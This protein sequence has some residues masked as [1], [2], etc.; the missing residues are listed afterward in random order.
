MAYEGTPALSVPGPEGTL[1][2]LYTKPANPRAP[3]VLALPPDPHEVGTMTNRVL[4]AM[5]RAFQTCG[6]AVLR[7]NYR[8]AERSP[9]PPPEEN[10]TEV[11]D[12]AAALD[13]LQSTHPD[14]T[15]YWMA[16]YSLGAWVALQMLMRR[17]EV[18]GFVAVSPRV[19]FCDFSFLNPCPSPGLVVTGTIDKKVSKKQTDQ[20]VNQ[21]KTPG[22]KE[23][24][25]KRVPKA[26]HQY[27]AGTDDLEKTIVNYLKNARRGR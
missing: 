6:F 14:T 19:D 16:G 23:I 10:A 22:G 3:V 15:D 20:F 17:P 9:M 5:H 2:V 18:N 13:Y 25:Y 27:A 21:L 7:I 1:D 11:A 12:A 4:A 26:D 24:V 8:N